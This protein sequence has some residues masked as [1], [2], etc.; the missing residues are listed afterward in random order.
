MSKSFKNNYFVTYNLFLNSN[1]SLII[2]PEYEY[3]FTISSEDVLYFENIKL[4]AIALN[5]KLMFGGSLF[6]K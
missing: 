4:G 5:V 1:H 3:L 2:E 6:R